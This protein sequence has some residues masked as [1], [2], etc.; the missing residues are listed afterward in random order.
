M[1]ITIRNQKSRIRSVFPDIAFVMCQ[2]QWQTIE[3]ELLNGRD[4]QIEMWSLKAEINFSISY[5]V[6]GRESGEFNTRS[7]FYRLSLP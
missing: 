5:V 4:A 2:Q 3:K 7:V 1:N 6:R